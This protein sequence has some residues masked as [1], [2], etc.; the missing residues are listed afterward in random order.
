VAVEFR[1][2]LG[3]NVQVVSGFRVAGA[4]CVAAGNAQVALVG[5]TDLDKAI[6]YGGEVG[7]GIN[8][9]V[10]VDDRLRG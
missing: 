1:A 8:N 4:K 3:A 6:G 2:V 10:E 5:V 7:F 9:D